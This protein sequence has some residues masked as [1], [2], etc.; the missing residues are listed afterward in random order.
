MVRETFL[1][2]GAG[3]ALLDSRR[4]PRLCGNEVGALGAPDLRAGG[5]TPLCSYGSGF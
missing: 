4:R 1:L 5:R 3:F 2:L